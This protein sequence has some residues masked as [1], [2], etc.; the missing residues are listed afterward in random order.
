MDARREG[1]AT[2]ATNPTTVERTSERDLVVTR[3]VNGPPRLVFEAWTKAE[4]F[5]RW[6]V[7]RSY[8]LTLLACEMDVRVG[9]RTG[10]CFATKIRPWNSSA[11][12]SK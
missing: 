3:T 10:W 2:P 1:E 8:G 4:L 12:T 9:G 6:W 7:P 5:R 11:P